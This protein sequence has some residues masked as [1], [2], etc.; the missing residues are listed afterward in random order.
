VA[1][2]VAIPPTLE[3]KTGSL[4]RKTWPSQWEGNVP[5][6]PCLT[7]TVGADHRPVRMETGVSIDQPRLVRTCRSLSFPAMASGRTA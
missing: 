5:G 3:P 4:P 1:I 2:W 7:D 6:P